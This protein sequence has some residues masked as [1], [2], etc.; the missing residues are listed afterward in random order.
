[1]SSEKKSLL[2]GVPLL[3][4]AL[5]FAGA[6]R[7]VTARVPAGRPVAGRP[8]TARPKEPKPVP[9]PSP[10]H[11]TQ[12]VSSPTAAAPYGP[13][14]PAAYQAPS[15]PFGSTAS[16]RIF[17]HT[18]RWRPKGDCCQNVSGRLTVRYRA[19]AG[20]PAGSSTSANDGMGLF[21]NGTNVGGQ[22]LYS[23]AVTT[24]QVGTK[25]FALTPAMLANYRVSFLLQDD[26]TV[27]SASLQVDACCV[28]M[29]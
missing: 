2:W 17:R 28:N 26:S 19:L 24:G 29:K 5:A 20:G 9:C 11:I 13:D 1:M 25:T 27:I 14:F 8:L 12:T 23:G 16:N 15:P 22:M 4:A 7:P 6:S 10:V 3:I 21:V 18:F